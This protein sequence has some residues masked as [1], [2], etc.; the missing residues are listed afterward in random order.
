MDSTPVQVKQ[1][2][3]TLAFVA[4]PLSTQY[5]RVRTKTSRL[6]LNKMCPGRARHLSLD[7]CFNELELANSIQFDGRVKTN[8]IIISRN[9]IHLRCDHSR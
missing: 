5:Y 6:G 7:C 4:S 3:L 8:I 1:N 9:V 2:T